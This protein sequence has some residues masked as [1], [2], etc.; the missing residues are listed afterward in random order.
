M[1]T[2]AVTGNKIRTRSVKRM[3]HSSVGAYFVWAVVIFTNPASALDWRLTPT[4]GASATLTDNV[5]QSATDS[6]SSLIL[7]V[8]P[9]F[10]LRSEGSR[11]VEAAM[12]YGL[13]GVVRTGEDQSN[14]LFN[15][16]AA[17]GRAELIDDFL[18]IDGSAAVSQELISLLGSPADAT[19]NSSNRATTGSYAISPYIKKRFGTFANAEARYS[20]TGALFRDDAANNINSSSLSASLNSG[21]QFNKLFWGLDYFLRDAT[22]QGGQ[23]ARFEHVGAILG[24]D[25][26]SRVRAFGTL[27]YDSND[28]TSA[29][30]ASTSGS[31]WSLGM[32]WAPNRRTNVEASF[33]DSFFGRTYSFD[34]NYRTP[35]SVWT[36]SYD[37]GVSD[38]S[39]QLLNTQP[40]TVWNCGGVLFLG[41]GT[42]P[43]T[44]QSNCI[45]QGVA[46]IGTVPIGLANGVYVSKV[47]RGSAAWSKGRS[48]MGLNVFDTRRQYQQLV[49]LPED[50]VRGLTVNYG[51]RLQ[52]RTSLNAGLGFTNT[53]SPAGLESIAARDDDF[54]T[55][56]VGVSH[57]FG[58]RLSGALI[59]RH[60]WRDSNNPSADFTENNISATANMTF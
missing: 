30:G 35:F 23:D 40:V 50:S 17:N 5:N 59:Y 15:S 24:R 42:L 53:Q 51:Y 29:P 27:G 43:P 4:L 16:L 57:E 37:D 9:G 1:A 46:P 26:S 54:Y 36:V 48:S 49:G 19:V 28:Y 13:T 32:G 8:T 52:P 33:G 10:T 41:D 22:V 44:G 3:R 6:Q 20:L 31:S 45:A 7:G 55:A 60:Q 38:I 34:F 12:R 18:F 58:S 25:L 11:R 39:Q 56:N 14:D 47:W 21:S 2:M